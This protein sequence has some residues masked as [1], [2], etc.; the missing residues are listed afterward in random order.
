VQKY[1]LLTAESPKTSSEPQTAPDTP[2]TFASAGNDPEPQETPAMPEKEAIDAPADKEAP[3]QVADV[4][5]STQYRGTMSHFARIHREEELR[6][7]IRKNL[8]CTMPADAPTRQDTPNGR[9]NTKQRG[10]RLLDTAEGRALVARLCL[11]MY[12]WHVENPELTALHRANRQRKN[13]RDVALFTGRYGLSALAWAVEKAER[14]SLDN[15]A[16]TLRHMLTGGLFENERR[17][18]KG[19]LAAA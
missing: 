11:L 1:P 19:H 13:R 3:L 15:G 17:R 8:N 16:A 2:D 6:G 10:F 5:N 9:E 18:L 14:T 7:G 4:D 12:D